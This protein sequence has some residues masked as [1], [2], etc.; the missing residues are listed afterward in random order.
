MKRKK[1]NTPTK[2]GI[3][4]PSGK[5]QQTSAVRPS[6]KS[7]T[8]RK[9]FWLLSGMLILTLIISGFYL[10][11]ISKDLPS[12]TRLERIEPEMATQVYS[13]D[14]KIIHSFF[15]FNR[16]FTPFSKIPRAVIDALLST[17][18]RTFYNH[19]GISLY[20]LSGA[21]LKNLMALDIKAQGA[22]TVTQ[23]L[24]RNLYFGFAKTWDRKIKE[25]I[26]AIQ[27]E[28]TYSK[29]EILSMYLNITPFGNNAFGIKAAARRYFD[30][31]VEDLD[32]PEAAL[33]IG[34]LKGQTYYSPIRHPQRALK[35]RNVVLYSMMQNGCLNP[36][37][38][39]SLKQLPLNL[40]LHDPYEMSTA[41]YFT[42]YV[43]RQM[44]S[45]Q[46]SL[47]VNVYEDG[48]R[49][50][51][52]LNTEI[53][54]FMDSSIVRNIDLI[55]ER[56]RRQPVFRKLKKNLSDSAY[57]ALTMVQVAFVAIDPHNG[58]ILAMTGGRDFKKS[59]WNRVTQMARQPGSA[60]KPFLYTA[61]IDNGFTPADSYRDQPTVEIGP[62]STRWTPKNYTGTFSGKIVTLR[63]ALRRSLNSVAVRLIG[64]ITPRVV[65][66]YARNMGISSKLRPYSSLA[67]GSSEVKPLELV[68][69]YGTFANNG[70]HVK[71]VSIVK[72]EDKNGN[73]IYSAQPRKR[74]VL[75]SA[76]THIMNN[77]LQ[78]V[79]NRGTGVH[80]RTKYKFYHTAGG[81]TGTTNNNSDAWFVGFTPDLVAGVWTGLDDFQYTLGS[82]MDGSRAALPF[83][84][85]FMK[86]VY[87]SVQFEKKTFVESS[88]VIKLK[89]CSS[90]KKI[91][92]PLCPESYEEIFNIKYKP[93]ESCNIH[94]GRNSHKRSSRRK[95]F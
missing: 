20:R 19:W 45:L 89:I 39:D 64:D 94:T 49:I 21:L 77:L 18:D 38:Y 85:D 5:T 79:V 23:Q 68:S 12:L 73:L 36:A 9:L 95:R 62:D 92:T 69:A 65:I 2:T 17:E 67:L 53:Q 56:V 3:R 46:D 55:Q 41:P 27:I 76:T 52:T 59:K 1:R 93:T 91:A 32:V 30:K 54:R 40:K 48:L 4:F 75:S 42:E 74:E 7:S 14:G 70:V 58:H 83:W 33:L 60:F 50:Y 63:D 34:V 24:S 28:R 29:D 25:A 15:T 26:T 71:P 10:Y 80:T 72:I 47:G 44:N 22:S 88:D 66:R 57:N 8:K 61:A 31:E 78:N 13:A 86:S 87:D 6:S 81:K 82:G 84:A 11:S 43:R 51:T 90:S 37:A 16:T 35:R